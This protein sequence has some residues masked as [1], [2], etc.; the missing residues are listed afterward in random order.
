MT[1]KHLLILAV[2]IVIG[3]PVLGLL[4]STTH[5]SQLAVNQVSKSSAPAR[6]DVMEEMMGEVEDDLPQGMMG[7]SETAPMP[8]VVDDGDFTPGAERAIV[9]TGSMSLVVSDVRQTIQEISTIVTQINGLVTSS[10]VIERGGQNAPITAEIAVRVPVADLEATVEKIRPLATKV[11]AENFNAQDRTEQKVDLEAQIRNLE[12]TETQLMTIM[13]RAK[14]VE[15]TLK[16]QTELSN[17]RGRIERLQAQL[18]NLT[19]AAAMSTLHI[20]LSSQ[21]TDLPIVNPG[22]RSILEEIKLTLRE[23]GRLYRQLFV[24]GLKLVI[25]G[26]PVIIVAA[27]GFYLYQRKKTK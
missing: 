10:N 12:A 24:T 22:E 9:K 11:L 15:E 6:F 13:S 3:L 2:V 14:T 21:E 17:V 18:D 26:S 8:P 20:S 7:F 23:T 19:G 16:V 25:L 4:S 1:K 5:M 27:I